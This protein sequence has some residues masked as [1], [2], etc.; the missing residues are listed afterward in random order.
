MKVLAVSIVMLFSSFS[1]HAGIYEGVVGYTIG[2]ASCESSSKSD[3]GPTAWEC[4][5]GAEHDGLNV[6]ENIRTTVS[7]EPAG[8]FL[9]IS[10]CS[11]ETGCVDISRLEFKDSDQWQ[12]FKNLDLGC[13][14][15]KYRM[16]NAFLKYTVFHDKGWF[17]NDAQLGTPQQIPLEFLRKGNGLKIPLHIRDGLDITVISGK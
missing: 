2:S 14:L 9:M 15:F 16:K 3:Q 12:P 7:S 8:D 5:Y 4:Q 6:S 1:A 13:Y 11:K 10:L 17:R